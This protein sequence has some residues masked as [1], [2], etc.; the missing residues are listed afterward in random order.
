MVELPTLTRQKHELKSNEERLP[1]IADYSNNAQELFNKFSLVS[2][3]TLIGHQG[4]IYEPV[5]ISLYNFSR[6]FPYLFRAFH[7]TETIRTDLV[8][9]FELYVNN[10]PEQETQEA[11]YGMV[12]KPGEISLD[13]QFSNSG[14]IN[15]DFK[16]RDEHKKRLK[17]VI[18]QGNNFLRQQG[19][20]K[21]VLVDV[22]NYQYLQLE[23]KNLK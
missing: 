23:Q 8:F 15:M 20:S 2:V 22:I 21:N 1:K 17:R 4:S 18:N 7:K 9:K 11:V 10:D 13:I 12:S 16:T 14:K 5:P 3:R 19:I 6:T